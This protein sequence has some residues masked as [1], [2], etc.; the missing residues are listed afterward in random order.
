M[1]FVCAKWLLAPSIQAKKSPSTADLVI[2]SST[3]QEQV[4][5]RQW[6]SRALL[7]NAVF[8]TRRIFTACPLNSN[9]PLQLSPPSAR[10]TRISI[11]QHYQN[12][13]RGRGGRNGLCR[14]SSAPICQQG[15]WIPCLASPGCSSLPP[16]AVTQ[17]LLSLDLLPS[18][19]DL[20]LNYASF[21][22]P[23]VYLPKG[24][25]WPVVCILV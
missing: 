3:D 13:C 14:M 5:R 17:T 4:N 19:W 15:Y 25:M 2:G 22:L 7:A 21:A 8:S 12:A 18:P 16:L 9:F 6:H 11:N 20:P 1:T 24:S 10:H 23:R